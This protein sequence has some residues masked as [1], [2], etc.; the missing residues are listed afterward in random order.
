MSWRGWLPILGVLVFAGI[1]L[2]V[3]RTPRTRTVQLDIINGRHHVVEKLF[4]VTVRDE[5]V[6]TEFSNLVVQHKLEDK[7]E[8]VH[9]VHGHP[10]NEY[11]RFATMVYPHSSMDDPTTYI[12]EMRRLA[13]IDDEPGL[14]G[15]LNRITGQDDWPSI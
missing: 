11:R 9:I 2:L 8:W 15:L 6:D 3:V 12:L 14:N 4:G 7:P 13:K 1:M 10:G 5:I